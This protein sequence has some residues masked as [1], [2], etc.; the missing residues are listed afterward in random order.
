LPG[1]LDHYAPSTAVSLIGNTMPAV[2]QEPTETLDFMN[3]GLW[4]RPVPGVDRTWASK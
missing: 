3:I 4:S 1:E 2:S